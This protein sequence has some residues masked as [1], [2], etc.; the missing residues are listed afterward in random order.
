MKT[1]LSIIA[2]NGT[3]DE[4]LRRS[5]REKGITRFPDAGT[6]RFTAGHSPGTRNIPPPR[7]CTA[8]ASAV[9][10][11]HPLKYD[12]RP[13]PGGTHNRH[14]NLSAWEHRKENV[15]QSKHQ[16][17]IQD[18]IVK[19]IK[20]WTVFCTMWN[21]E[22]TMVLHTYVQELLLMKYW[23]LPYILSKRH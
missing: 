9:V 11:W 3:A 5:H 7:P 19:D 16:T 14:S 10:S 1:L 22:R 20:S 17:A 8:T 4:Q 12:L 18:V 15:R 13:S 21:C 23:F 2:Y 6:E